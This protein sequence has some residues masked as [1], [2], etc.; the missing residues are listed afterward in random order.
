MSPIAKRRSGDE[1]GWNPCESSADAWRTSSLMIKDQV[2]PLGKV[3][4]ESLGERV[5][6]D[7]LVSEPSG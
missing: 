2:R 4:A 7:V 3:N 6:I 5:P 1:A